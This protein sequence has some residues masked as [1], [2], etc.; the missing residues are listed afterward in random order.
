MAPGRWFESSR[1]QLWAML[2]AVLLCLYCAA[3]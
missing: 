3:Y 2:P 1:G